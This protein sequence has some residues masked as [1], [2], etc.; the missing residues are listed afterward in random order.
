MDS[1]KVLVF[2]A[3]NSKKDEYQTS[4]ET[5]GELKSEI[6]RSFNGKKVTVK[7]T[8]VNLE[9]DAAKLPEGNITLFLFNKESKFG[10]EEGEEQI[11]KLLRKI[12][13]K[14]KPLKALKRLLDDIEEIE[15]LSEAASQ[16]KSSLSY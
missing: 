7:E 16:V 12:D 5:F 1:R 11:I 13:K 4:V 10:S 9:S 3:Q 15:R 14:L 8:Q 2:D 6:G